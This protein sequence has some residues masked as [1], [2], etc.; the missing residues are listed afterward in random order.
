MPTTTPDRAPF[1]SAIAD[2]LADD[3]RHAG[4]HHAG[5][6]YHRE[7]DQLAPAVFAQILYAALTAPAA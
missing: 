1:A 7:A 5:R 3:A 4:T 6:D 2:V